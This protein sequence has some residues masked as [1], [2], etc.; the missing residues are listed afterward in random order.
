MKS[1]FILTLIVFASFY[2]KA[3]TV[4]PTVFSSQGDYNSSSQGNNSWTIGEP[5]SGTSTASNNITT[6]GFQQPNSLDVVTFIKGNNKNISLF[7]YPNPVFNELVIDFTGVE[8]GNYNV[9]LTDA[10]GKLIYQSNTK[11]DVGSN[12]KMNLSFTELANAN[13][14]VTISNASNG[15][16]KTF[17]IVKSN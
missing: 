12:K 4:T 5:I 11:V 14:F 6:M 17:K 8:S 13:Y 10:V 15:V 16:N 1:K 2:V 7:V 9:Q 3:Q